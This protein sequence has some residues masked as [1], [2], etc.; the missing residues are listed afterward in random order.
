MSEPYAQPFSRAVLDGLLAR[1]PTAAADL[2][3]GRAAI[4]A[5]RVAAVSRGEADFTDDE[6]GVIEDLSDLTGL[7]LA[8]AVA[9]PDGGPLT[10]MADGWATVRDVGK[11]T[12]NSPAGAV[13]LT[14]GSKGWPNG[15]R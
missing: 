7:Q 5:G 2:F 3:A 9:E 12:A 14:V 6:I 4:P 11:A 1:C 13:P 15:G 8:A 10:T